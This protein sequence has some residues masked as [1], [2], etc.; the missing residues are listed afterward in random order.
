MKPT[1][2]AWLL[3]PGLV[4]LLSAAGTPPEAT[5][6]SGVWDV[7]G[8]CLVCHKERTP[9]L[10]AEWLGSA[11]ADNN[12]TCFD[13]HGARRDEA[14]AF[15]HQGV[16]IS[17]LVTPLDCAGCHEV[18]AAG[19]ERSAHA[20]AARVTSPEDASA[21]TDCAG[22]H[23]GT[24][25]LDEERPNRLDDRSWQGGAVGRLNPDGS[26]GNCSACHQ[27]HGFHPDAPSTER[28]CVQC[29]RD[30]QAN[31]QGFREH[32]GYG[33]AHNTDTRWVAPSTHWKHGTP[34][35]NAPTCVSCHLQ[36]GG[37]AHTSHNSALRLGRQT[38]EGLSVPR[39][40]GPGRAAMRQVCAQCHGASMVDEHFRRL[41][42]A[43]DLYN[44]RLAQPAG[45]ILQLLRT[46]RGGDARAIADAEQAWW[47]LLHRAEIRACAGETPVDADPAR[48]QRVQETGRWFHQ[49]FAP[50]V[51]RSGVEGAIRRLDRLIADDPL[52]RALAAAPDS[53]RNTAD[54]TTTTSRT[55]TERR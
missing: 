22:C 46:S 15:P 54:K 41:D 55:E 14:D 6:D 19:F 38:R 2:L 29:H 45:E 13:C 42:R 39:S 23:G 8:K 5:D 44:T 26:R 40:D 24:V 7:K 31:A 47:E 48:W 36:D 30:V 20:R 25:R 11:H 34:V 51:R 52:H 21:D 50:A 28:A 53:G 43:L 9:G 10:Y 12:V 32:S 37:G 35:E 3:L 18:E 17:T 4:L 27:D 49:R 16:W 1:W 33:A